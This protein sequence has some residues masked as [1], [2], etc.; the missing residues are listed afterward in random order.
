MFKDKFQQSMLPVNA[1]DEMESG[2]WIDFNLNLVKK[3]YAYRVDY[4][5]NRYFIIIKCDKST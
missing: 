3:Y 2:G 4:A 5:Q 1:F